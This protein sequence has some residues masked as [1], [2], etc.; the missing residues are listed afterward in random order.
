MNRRFVLVTAIVSA[1]SPVA[2]AELRYT[3]TLAGAQYPTETGSAATGTATL[4]VDTETQTIDAQIVITGLKFD[5]LAQHLAHSRMGPMHLHRYQGED[6]TLIAPFPFGESYVETADGFT[7]TVTD[8]P[9]AEAAERTRSSLSFD[10]FIAALAN[11]PIY[12]NL[13]TEAFGD[14]EISGRVVSAD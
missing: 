1:A 12:L 10:Q 3:A 7:V 4:T 6:V 14:G 2:A 13:H 5:D 9:Y 8:F 11:D